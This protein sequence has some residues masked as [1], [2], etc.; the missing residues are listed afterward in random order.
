LDTETGQ[1]NL[2]HPSVVDVHS[3]LCRWRDDKLLWV[4]GGRELCVIDKRGI[5]YQ[6]RRLPEPHEDFHSVAWEGDFIYLANTIYNEID[7]LVFDLMTYL[8]RT[9]LF[10]HADRI[11]DACHLNSLAC[12][13]KTI[14]A[15]V[16]EY[17][18]KPQTLRT[19]E[20][21]RQ[22]PD[23]RILRIDHNGIYTVAVGL[24]KPHSLLVDGNDVFFCNSG[25]GELIGMK[26]DYDVT[27]VV[28]VAADRFVRG[29]ARSKNGDL[30]VGASVYR[31]DDDPIL[32]SY[33][34]K[35]NSKGDF[36]AS[37]FIPP[38]EVYDIVIL[39]D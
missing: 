28:K 26:L 11:Y 37:W 2:S 1:C 36:L 19:K 20:G 30:F 16:F 14:Y 24:D 3:G 10:S 21:W 13:D 33:V 23:G 4:Y 22:T 8:D 17:D 6:R 25:T 27:M 12:V 15:T 7:T 35:Y 38:Q 39:E 5:V 32:R 29:L 18:E 34:A 9:P 31:E